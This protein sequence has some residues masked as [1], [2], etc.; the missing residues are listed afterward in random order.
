MI[1]LAF[2]VKSFSQLTSLL[3]ISGRTL[4]MYSTGRAVLCL[5]FVY[6]GALRALAA[7]RDERSCLWPGRARLPAHVTGSAPL[8]IE[9]GAGG[10][11]PGHLRQ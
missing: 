10:A 3:N 5:P 8:F 6:E 2:T 11:R 7:T 9:E 4:Q 1:A